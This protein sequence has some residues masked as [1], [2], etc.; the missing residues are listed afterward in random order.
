MFSLGLEVPV[1]PDSDISFRFLQDCL[2]DCLSN[3]T[4]CTQLPPRLPAVPKR[5][6]KIDVQ[7]S[8]PKLVE[9]PHGVHLPY[10]ALSYRW[11]SLASLQTT[12]S[13]IETFKQGINWDIIPEVFR[14]AFTILR[15]LD[16]HYIWIDSLCIIQDDARDWQIQATSMEKI[17][18][19]AVITIAAA[20]SK[21]VHEGFLR[22]RKLVK[23][24]SLS[25]IEHNQRIAVNARK[26]IKLGIHATTLA[27]R[28]RDPLDE[29]A[30][31]L[32]EREL[33]TRAV[34][35]T[36]AEMQWA[37][38]TLRRCQC[39][40][41]TLNVAEDF[42]NHVA[43]PKFDIFPTWHLL[44]E[45][46]TSRD[47]TKPTDK[48]PAIQGLA[49]RVEDRGLDDSRGTDGTVTR[50]YIAGLWRENLLVDL[51]WERFPGTRFSAVPQYRAPSFSWASVDGMV[52]YRRARIGYQGE[53]IDHAQVLGANCRYGGATPNG[54]VADG[55]VSLSGCLITAHLSSSSP[56]D[57][58][59][60][61]LS[62]AKRKYIHEFAID[63]ALLPKRF[64][65]LL[66]RPVITLARCSDTVVPF[67]DVAV[68]CLSL[69]SIRTGDH[70]YENMLL[71]CPSARMQGAYERI[72]IM[73]AKWERPSKLG[74]GSLTAIKPFTWIQRGK[75]KG[76]Q[77][78]SLKAVIKIV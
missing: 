63:T 24:I 59:T 10:A 68:S 39:S 43:N 1:R 38:N 54:E 75:E 52:S 50:A 7:G 8:T 47:L 4:A 13:T 71:L 16:L 30:W 2:S 25:I 32:Q 27:H 62:V 36:G 40:T 33:S 35:Y 60:Y 53:R 78:R 72:G 20:S 26:A 42:A 67:K 31:A 3:H 41:Q 77:A 70:L 58:S 65:K 11:G 28:K 15:K 44:V 12:R 57:P 14:D 69:C 9:P 55:F 76:E 56:L 74:D 6:I 23:S 64:M 45:E 49:S 5:L 48:L 19:N 51:C 34:Y 21:G 37:C 61:S 29:R 22:E 73:T 18:T 17:Y 46:Y 66:F